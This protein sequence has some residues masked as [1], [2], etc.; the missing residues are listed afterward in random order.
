MKQILPIT[1]ILVLLLTAVCIFKGCGNQATTAEEPTIVASDDVKADSGHMVRKSTFTGSYARMFNDLPD[2]HMAAA[3][4]YGI[5]PITALSDVWRLPRPIERISSCEDFE[6]DELTHSYPYLV[7]DAARLLHDIGS[8]F[9]DSLR[10]RGYAEYR[11]IVTSALRT[12]ASVRRLSRRN[13]NAVSNSSH[14]YGTTFD[15]THTKYSRVGTE[16][17]ECHPMEL[18]R[19][20]AEVLIDLRDRGRCLVKYER[21]Q[22]C[23]HITVS[24]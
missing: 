14:L 17:R 16:G 9:R 10:S 7:P 8:A 13:V 6:I 15:I 2:A 24:H 22:P 4:R 20:L 11:P 3:E 23:F 5:P 12:Q 21:K 1:I 19:I 18:K